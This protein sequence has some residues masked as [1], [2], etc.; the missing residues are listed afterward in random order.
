MPFL[1]IR[2]CNVINFQSK[3]LLEVSGYKPCDSTFFSEIKYK[4]YVQFKKKFVRSILQN[5]F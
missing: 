5:V 3:I 1:M 2:Y 4:M